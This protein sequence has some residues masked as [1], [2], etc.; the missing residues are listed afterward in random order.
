MLTIKKLMYLITSTLKF[1]MKMFFAFQDM[2]Y[3]IKTKS[4]FHSISETKFHFVSILG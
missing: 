2:K 3:N 1:H 4:Y